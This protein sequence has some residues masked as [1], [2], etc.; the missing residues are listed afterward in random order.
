MLIV[1]TGNS[2]RSQMAEALA[3]KLGGSD[4]EI[5]SAGSMPAGYIH[6]YAIA[7]MAELG[8][9]LSSRRSK[10]IA[11][12]L[13]VSFDY[14]ITV[15]DGAKEDCPVFPNARTMLH[16]PTDDP[17]SMRDDPEAGMAV[18]RRVRG[19]LEEKLATLMRQDARGKTE[20]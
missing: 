2:C 11:E 12:F 13:G 14:V 5:C 18:A 17:A 8:I 6:R 1:C 3:Q 7:A 4:W 10:G 15:C 9:D 20:A 19:E 16:W